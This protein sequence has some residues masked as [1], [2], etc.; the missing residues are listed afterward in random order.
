MTDEPGRFAPNAEVY[1]P[2][3]YERMYRPHWFLRNRRKYE[4]REA[5]LLRIVKP[6]P[7]TRLLEVGSARGDTAFFLAPRVAEVVGI[8]AAKA[9]VA[10]ARSRLAALA[11]SNVRFEEADARDLTTV[12]GGPFDV[13]LLADFVEHVLDDVLVPCL[14]SARTVLRPGGVLAIYTPNARHWAERL[15]AAVPFLQ[16]EDH[17]AVRPAARVAHLVEAAGFRV[18]DLFFSASP[19]PVLGALDRALPMVGLCRF[20][21]CLRAVTSP[22]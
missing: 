22:A 16:Q 11:L 8:D 6:S 4:E 5:A 19:Y 21:T 12:P 9:A 13:V 15:K 18:E 3:Y 17:I 10:A 1:G 2:G 14:S 7:S 20:R